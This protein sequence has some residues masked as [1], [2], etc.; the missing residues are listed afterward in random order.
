MDRNI[1][2]L[3]RKNIKVNL[4]DSIITLKKKEERMTE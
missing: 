3:Y 1:K 2:T 4:R